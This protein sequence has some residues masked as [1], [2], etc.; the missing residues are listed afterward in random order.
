MGGLRALSAMLG[1]IGH[2]T[3]RPIIGDA[4]YE[5]SELDKTS[6]DG[7]NSLS[8]GSERDLESIYGRSISLLTCTPSRTA[9]PRGFLW[10][11]GFHQLLVS[12]WNPHITMKVI[13]DWMKAMYFPSPDAI[14]DVKISDHCVGGWI[15]R[16]MI[17]GAEATARVPA[18]FVTQRPNI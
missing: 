12:S 15:P 8:N 17:L 3:G 13:S 10:D 1:G 18:D 6:T 11:E 5:S 14:D 16:E 4:E 9:F 2:F 7:I